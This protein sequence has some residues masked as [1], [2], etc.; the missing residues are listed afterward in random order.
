MECSRRNQS[1]NDPPTRSAGFCANTMRVESHGLAF[2]WESL[3]SVVLRPGQQPTGAEIA[4]ALL[5]ASLLA[6]VYSALGAGSSGD[7]GSIV[8]RQVFYGLERF[9]FF[10]VYCATIYSWME[11]DGINVGACRF[12]AP[13]FCFLFCRFVFKLRENRLPAQSTMSTPATRCGSPRSTLALPAP[14]ATRLATTTW[15]PLPASLCPPSL[16]SLPLSSLT[17][18]GCSRRRRRRQRDGAAVLSRE[19]S[20]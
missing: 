5:G 7:T 14:A 6:A 1:A 9:G 18:A 3:R 17:T 16:P 2:A 4:C 12:R 8:L 10:A 20:Q 15:P 19:C 13:A 11:N